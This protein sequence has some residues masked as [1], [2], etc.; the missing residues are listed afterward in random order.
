MTDR[1][2]DL[3]KKPLLFYLRDDDGSA[4]RPAAWFCPGDDCKTEVMRS[5]RY[6]PYCGQ[7]LDWSEAEN[8]EL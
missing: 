7:R 3:P 1:N 8:D 5:D 2:R 4:V 6:C